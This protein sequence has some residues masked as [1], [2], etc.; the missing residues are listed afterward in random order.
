MWQFVFGFGAGVYVGTFFDCKPTIQQVSSILTQYCPPKKE[1]EV[2]QKN[3]NSDD[4]KPSW[5][6]FWK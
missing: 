4:N 6:R 2:G 5:P 3:E 1:E